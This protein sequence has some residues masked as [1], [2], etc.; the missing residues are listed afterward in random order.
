MEIRKKWAP[1]MSTT[2]ILLAKEYQIKTYI[3]Y[4]FREQGKKKIDIQY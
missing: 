2:W 3:P 1:E 4:T